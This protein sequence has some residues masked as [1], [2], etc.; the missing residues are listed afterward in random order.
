M[1]K[2][3]LLATPDPWAIVIGIGLLN[4]QPEAKPEPKPTPKPEAT[5][6]SVQ[7]TVSGFWN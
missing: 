4:A 2:P 6:Q 1:T 3:E 5:P 7:P